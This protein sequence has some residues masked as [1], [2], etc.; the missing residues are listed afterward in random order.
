M[1]HK[2]ID[3][4]LWLI[5]E[6]DISNRQEI[7]TLLN[8]IPKDI[9]EEI[10]GKLESNSESYLEGGKTLDNGM[11][12]E[13]EIDFEE[14]EVILTI[15]HG[16][17]SNVGY[18]NNIKMGVEFTLVWEK[19]EGMSEYWLGDITYICDLDMDVDIDELPLKGFI[20]GFSLT[21]GIR[22]AIKEVETEY[23]LIVTPE[24][25]CVEFNGAKKGINPIDI[26][27]MPDNITIEYINNR[28]GDNPLYKKRIM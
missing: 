7:I 14:D 12:L 15:T 3:K 10:K 25:I 28:Y 9:L 4:A 23:S 20:P 21:H 18:E 27:D 17:I 8:S 2:E 13:Y 22:G 6:A 19:D 24:A 1:F 11:A 5:L 16:I 26:S